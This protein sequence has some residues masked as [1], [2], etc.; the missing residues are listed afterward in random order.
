M[1]RDVS[2]HDSDAGRDIVE[3]LYDAFDNVYADRRLLNDAV[4]VITHL[5]TRSRNDSLEA[6]LSLPVMDPV[7]LQ[8]R[9]MY[10]QLRYGC[11][12]DVNH[13]PGYDWL[14]EHLPDAVARWVLDD[15]DA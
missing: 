1:Q 3:R 13:G 15:G 10:G 12:D 9:F 4:T 6:L 7:R 5:R 2:L 8:L 14:G 11:T